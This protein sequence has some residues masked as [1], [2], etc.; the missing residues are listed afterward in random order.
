M[1]NWV[2]T[3]F[4]H[5]TE[6]GGTWYSVAVAGRDGNGEKVF[7]YMPVDFPK[8][9]EIGDRAKVE[10]KDFFLSFFTKR[11][12]ST[13]FKFVVNDFLVQQVQPQ[14]PMP[15]QGYPQQ[16]QYQ[17][18]MPQQYYGGMGYPQPMQQMPLQPQ[19]QMVQPQVMPQAPV[20]APQAQPD[21]EQIN[22]DVPF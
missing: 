22:E 14:Q 11:D 1:N 2:K 19:A 13:Q 9:T 18:P 7:Q 5:D 17:Q 3:I 8:G 4:R 6:Q 12:G 10:F 21:F 20:Q 16:V 15:P